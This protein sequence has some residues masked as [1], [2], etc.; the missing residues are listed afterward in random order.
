MRDCAGNGATMN[1]AARKLNHTGYIQ[2]YC[3][4]VNTEEKV[5]KLQNQ[6]QLSDSIAKNNKEHANEADHKRIKVQSTYSEVAPVAIRKLKAKNGDATKYTKKEIIA[7]LFFVFYTLEEDKNKKD[8][9]VAVL[10]HHAGNY[11]TKF[12]CLRLV[13]R[14]AQAIAWDADE[15]PFYLGTSMDKSATVPMCDMEDDQD[16][17]RISA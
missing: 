13:P 10:I 6:L 14:L 2:C 5:H 15:S 9:I 8:V 7:V 17:H 4:L 1:L 12:P 11:H 3:G 16:V